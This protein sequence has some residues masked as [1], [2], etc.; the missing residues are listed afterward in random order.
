M[1]FLSLSIFVAA[2]SVWFRGKN[3]ELPLVAISTALLFALPNIRNS[4][5]GV[6][7]PVGTTEDSGSNIFCLTQYTVCSHVPIYSGR[8]LLEYPACRH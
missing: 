7:S 6:P 1:W 8:L 3:A 5:P 4:Q 2:M